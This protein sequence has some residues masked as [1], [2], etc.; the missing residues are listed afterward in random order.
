[1]KIYVFWAN[2]VSNTSNTRSHHIF[3]LFTNDSQEWAE[4]TDERREDKQGSSG[5]TSE[6]Y[7]CRTKQRESNTSQKINYEQQLLDIL[8]EKSEHTDEDKTF[9]LSLVPGLQN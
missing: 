3:K 2:A 8:K 5:G 9:L 6:T 1:V 7:T 4:D